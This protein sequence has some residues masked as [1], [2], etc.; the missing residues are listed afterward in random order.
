MKE[1]AK[2]FWRWITHNTLG[3]LLLLGTSALLLIV[4]TPLILGSLTL[5]AKLA[6]AVFIP[7]TI[8]I[9]SAYLVNLLHKHIIIPLCSRIISLITWCI[10]T[11]IPFKPFSDFKIRPQVFNTPNV[12]VKK[13]SPKLH[14]L[15]LSVF[16]AIYLHHCYTL[17]VMPVIY[18]FIMLAVFGAWIGAA[19][20]FSKEKSEDFE[21]PQGS[22]LKLF[23]LGAMNGLILTGL[24]LT[25]GHYICNTV[26]ELGYL[27]H[28]AAMVL[29]FFISEYVEEAIL[30][31]A[32]DK[33]NSNQIVV[34]AE[35]PRDAIRI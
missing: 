24:Q 35:N 17:I 16:I 2:N 28:A 10:T 21:I 27:G 18:D 22:G 23:G 12:M 20:Q 1:K 19:L 5:S 13:L 14:Y 33:L 29:N 25:I 8:F 7:S 4:G 31:V 11:K 6:I 15:A 34:E 26:L 30:Y 9:F 3:Q 32:F